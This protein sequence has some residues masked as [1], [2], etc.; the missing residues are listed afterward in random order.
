MQVSVEIYFTL[1]NDYIFT[2][3]E[4]LNSG[5]CSDRQF[6]EVLDTTSYPVGVQVIYLYIKIILLNS[7]LWYTVSMDSVV[8]QVSI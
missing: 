5:M 3:D 8:A 1:L 6:V 4:C 2:Q 7:C